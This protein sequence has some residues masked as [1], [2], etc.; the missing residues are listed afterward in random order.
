MQPLVSVVIP[1]YNR[2][3]LLKRAIQSVSEQTFQ[4]FEIVV[5]DDGTEERAKEVVDTFDD[6]RIRYIEHEE[7]KGSSAAKNTAFRAAK[8][9][10]IAILDD[11]DYWEPEKLGRQVHALEGAP[12]DVGFSFTAGRE[13]FDER[14]GITKAPEGINNYHDL[15]LRSFS[16]IIDSS[17][18]FKRSLLDTVGMYDESL[19]TH[20]GADFV[21]RL[22][23]HAQG[24]GINESLVVRKIESGHV[25]MG[26]NIHN[27]IRGRETVLARYADE[28]ASRPTCLAK[29]LEQLGRFYRDAG[30]YQ[31]ARHAF[32]RAFTL[33]PRVGR[34]LRVIFPFI[35]RI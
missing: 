10:Y 18:V 8:G 30:E 17:L 11:D 15:S 24:I 5:V 21:I 6:D 27:R 13:I 29:H 20:T 2:P 35:K 7:N 32:W 23:K 34:L 19:P 1:T 9:K 3:D 22:T 31:K 28:F 14:E 12:S 4:D 33:Q 25:Q 16:A 26:S